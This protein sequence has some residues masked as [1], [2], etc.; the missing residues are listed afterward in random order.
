MF[1]PCCLM[2]R[3]AGTIA[4][5]AGLLLC[6]AKANA[7]PDDSSNP[8]PVGRIKFDESDL[9]PANV[10]L[11]L[12]S[13][14][15]SIAFLRTIAMKTGIG[16]FLPRDSAMPELLAGTLVAVPLR[17]KRL[18]ATQVTLVQLATRNTT[19]SGLRV[20]QLLVER[21]KERKS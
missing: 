11:D 7:K 16:T 10:E 6:T 14:T 15:N 2:L 8:T 21:M 12:Y 3:R 19:P 13:E 17:D 5:L 1:E 20:A 4:A 9:P 18:D